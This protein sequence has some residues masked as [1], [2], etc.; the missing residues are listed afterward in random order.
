MN[1]LREHCRLLCLVL[2]R[3]LVSDCNVTQILGLR[4]YSAKAIVVN[5][6]QVKKYK[7][8]ARLRQNKWL[9]KNRSCPNFRSWETCICFRLSLIHL[10]FHARFQLPL[11]Q[12]VWTTFTLSSCY[13]TIFL[14]GHFQHPQKH[15]FS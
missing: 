10:S 12:E 4:T 6:T 5:V 9:D 2:L 13:P 8:C 3:L 1:Y 7:N 15:R 14:Q 11:L